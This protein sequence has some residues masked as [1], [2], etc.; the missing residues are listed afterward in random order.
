MTRLKFFGLKQ[1]RQ[2]PTEG[3][4]N[5]GAQGR[6][7]LRHGDG[8]ETLKK[9]LSPPR[10]HI[11]KT[12]WT[13]TVRGLINY[14]TG[15]Q[16]QRTKKCIDVHPVIRAKRNPSTPSANSQLSSLAQGRDLQVIRC[17]HAVNDFGDRANPLIKTFVHLLIIGEWMPSCSFLRQPRDKRLIVAQNWLKLAVLGRNPPR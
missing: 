13:D 8:W 12:V 4:V 9:T 14:F 5:L 1:G 16:F 7:Q 6:L 10:K 17:Q 3:H 2:L 11:I 15:N